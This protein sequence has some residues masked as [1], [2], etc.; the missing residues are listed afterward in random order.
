V[1]P[2]DAS[3]GLKHLFHGGGLQAG[4]VHQELTRPGMGNESSDYLDGLVKRHGKNDYIGFMY[5]PLGRKRRTQV[6]NIDVKS[7][8]AEE[9]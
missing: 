8:R 2:D 4:Q 9:L 3:G 5:S 1:K 6:G 7:M